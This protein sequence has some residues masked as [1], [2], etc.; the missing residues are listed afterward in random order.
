MWNS[1]F[2]ESWAIRAVVVAVHAY[3][4][5]PRVLALE[6]AGELPGHLDGR[7]ARI[8]AV[9]WPPSAEVFTGAL[10]VVSDDRDAHGVVVALHQTAW[11]ELIG[12]FCEGAR[13]RSAAHG[14]V[15]G[16]EAA[17]FFIGA[18]V[19]VGASVAASKVKGT[20]LAHHRCGNASTS[21]RR[22][23]GVVITDHQP[24][25]SGRAAIEV[26][27]VDV[28]NGR[29]R[30][31]LCVVEDDRVDDIGVAAAVAREHVARERG[32]ADLDQRFGPGHDG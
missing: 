18:P 27:L 6:L 31:R 28:F 24:W 16:Q 32:C 14:P 15:E 10:G 25:I 29:G 17:S 5:Q 30:R 7:R 3:G 21:I 22:I 2:D 9:G 23:D 4:L 20:A 1:I 13:N 8:P 26:H 11:A 12:R 19:G